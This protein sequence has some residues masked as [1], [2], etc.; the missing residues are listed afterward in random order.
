MAVFLIILSTISAFQLFELPYVMLNQT[1]GPDDA[2]LT[3]VMYLYENGFV[4]GDLG[5]ASAIG[6]TLAVVLLLL[7]LL[8]TRMSDAWKEQN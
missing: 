1:A 5:Y 3:I 7:A 6:W 4:T 8:E 2:G